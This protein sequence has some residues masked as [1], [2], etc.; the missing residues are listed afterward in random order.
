MNAKLFAT[1]FMLFFGGSQ[2]FPQLQILLNWMQYAISF[3]KNSKT[4]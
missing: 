2:Q 1:A 4:G 3:C